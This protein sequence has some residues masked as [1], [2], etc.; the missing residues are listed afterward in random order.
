MLA[1]IQ[2]RENRIVGPQKYN[3]AYNMLPVMGMENLR[4]NNAVPSSV[5]S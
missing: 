2:I 5:V 1:W 3:K 4:K